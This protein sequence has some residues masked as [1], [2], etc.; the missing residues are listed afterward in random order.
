MPQHS[1]VGTV[2]NFSGAAA[3]GVV[4]RIKEPGLI[5]RIS[6]GGVKSLFNSL[7]HSEIWDFGIAD[8]VH[9][10]AT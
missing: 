9:L 2:C 5:T 6:G 3:V 4:V 10:A 8:C 1:W 7:G